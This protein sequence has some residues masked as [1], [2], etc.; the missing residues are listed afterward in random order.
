VK[1]FWLSTALI[2]AATLAAGSLLSFLF[3]AKV[4]DQ[5]V[6]LTSRPAPP[7]VVLAK[8]DQGSIDFYSRNAGITWPWPRSLY[9]RAID[10]LAAAGA[11][12][13]VLDMVFSEPS[14]YGGEDEWL[15]ASTAAA[16]R[17]FLPLF[18]TSN[19]GGA[20][21]L[22]RL[23]LPRP[24]RLPRMPAREGKVTL[25]LPMLLKAMRGGGNAQANPDRD[26][27]YRRIGLFVSRGKRVY[28]A[29]A[30]ATAIYAQPGLDLSRV[31]FAADG[32]M[33]LRFYRK[34]SFRTYAISELIQSQVRRQAG[35]PPYVPAV[36]LKDK[37]VVIGA[38]ASALLD[39]RATPIDPAGA[40]FELHATALANLL[41]RDHIRVLA[42]WLQWLVV[43]LAIV[44]LNLLLPRIAS[45]PWQLLAVLAAVAL[46]LAGNF[47]AFRQGLDLDLI[48][49]LL[50]LVAGS[51]ADAFERYQRVRREK[52][53][54]EKAFKGYMSDAL[55]A[56]IMKNPAGL[57]LGGEKKLVTIFFSDLAGFTT[58][59]ETLPAEEVVRVLNTYLER[60]TSIIMAGG[61]FVNKFEGDAIMAF[62]GAPLPDERHAARAMRAALLCQEDLRALNEE[63]ARDG[64]P[65]LGMRI[66]INSGEVIVGN[67]GSRQRFE[68]TVIGDAVNLA[69]RLE[70]INKQ[71]GTTIIC[72]AL[73]GRLAAGEMVLR[74]LD[75]VRVKGKR[76]PEEIFEVKAVMAGEA[77]ELSLLQAAVEKGL[78]LY[79]AGD[80]A[81]ALDAFE[82]LAADPPSRVFAERCR[83][84]LAHPPAE[85]D[86]VWTFTEK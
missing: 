17:V 20:V 49:L 38:T 24:P 72:G 73:A 64:L 62:W 18:F 58:L 54:I 83:F 1:R 35:E 28:P 77:A 84:L 39:N 4:Y 66:G 12:A 25:P 57:H 44:M 67:I 40:G 15:A 79:F 8:I 27:V 42:P 21:G 55:L 19:A 61:G 50:A 56:E 81:A 31:P 43:L 6:R 14:P 75:R 85:W 34:G 29:L 48:P 11:R 78:A 53:F 86:G 70:G 32:G 74:R 16:G 45:L 52:K 22:E 65:R 36:E 80:F 69:S 23:A 37:V 47:L 59:S 51:G 7:A 33:S 13:V 41:R 82:P 76:V 9:A 3:E 46:A 26:H 71:Y 5:K 10:Y 60:M 63:F 68:Y 2:F 30:L